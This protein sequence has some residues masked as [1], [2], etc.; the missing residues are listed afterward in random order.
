[1]NKAFKTKLDA[2]IAAAQA[3]TEKT[4]EKALDKLL[5][6]DAF[7][8]AQ[9]TVNAK[10][11]EIEKLNEVLIQL[12]AIAPY[13]ARD[14]RKFRINVFPINI[15]GT[16]LGEVM[17]VVQGSRG[18]FVAEKMLEYSAISGISMLELTEAQTALGSPAYY[19]DGKVN[20]AIPGNFTALSALLQGI[21]IK[22]GLSEFRAD[23]VTE[24]K[25]NLWFA[26]AEA[27][28]NKQLI[29][30]QELSKLE[31]DAEDFVLTED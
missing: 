22:L 7:I 24:D 5:D 16:G 18:A 2:K 12:N 9:R 15:F 6:N 3:K 25:Y 31:A 28:A 11:A 17:G 27:K 8:E 13:V 1:M 20:D 14:G 10:E 4:N 21:F 19:K 23:Q 26:I 29:E 30:T